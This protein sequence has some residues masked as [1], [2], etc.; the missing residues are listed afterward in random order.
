MVA[1]FGMGGPLCLAAKV[2]ISAIAV[3]SICCSCTCLS[4]EVK[5]YSS[6]RVS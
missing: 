1:V 2:W 3:L 6:E 4:P 5:E